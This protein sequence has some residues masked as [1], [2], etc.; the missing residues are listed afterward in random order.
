MTDLLNI[1]V[2][3]LVCSM[4][5]AIGGYVGWITA[6]PAPSVSSYDTSAA[7]AFRDAD[8]EARHATLRAAGIIK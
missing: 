5:A 2:L 6:N 4:L 3:V 8:R 1:K 7:Q